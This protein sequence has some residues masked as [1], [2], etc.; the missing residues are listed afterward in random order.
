MDLSIIIVS[1]NTKTLLKNC[2]DSIKKKVM[3]LE[4]E[5]IIIDNASKD[6]SC[7]FIKKYYKDIILIES[8]ENLGFGRANNLG[9]KIAR[10]KYVLL[11]NSDTILI[12][13][14]PKILFDF[15]QKNEKVG[16]CGGKLVT[17]EGELNISFGKLPSVFT[18]LCSQPKF[19][20]IKLKNTIV[21]KKRTKLNC[22]EVEWI[23]GADMFLRKKVL[24]EVGCF[25]DDFFMYYEETELISRIRKKYKI[26]FV[27]EAEIIHLEGGSF[28][29]KESRERMILKSKYLY[30]QK[31][32]GQKSVGVV[33]YIN[34]FYNYLRYLFNIFSLK[35]KRKYLEKII[36]LNKEAY[37]NWKINIK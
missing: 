35:E 37:K 8:K 7:S 17:K 29:L 18:E 4:Y 1:Y 21:S 2:L 24:D 15:M 34:N 32:Y 31:V 25:D 10:G 33:F 23:S 6:D 3:D 22:Q 16:V 19:Y 30:F 26:Y 14:A 9:I 27:P 20:I 5:I 28:V 36:E 11:L 12:N 13:N